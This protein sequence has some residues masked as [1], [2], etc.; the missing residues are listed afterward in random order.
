MEEITFSIF[1]HGRTASE[2][3]QVLLNQF[4]RQYGIHVRLEV[5]QF[6]SLRWPRLVEA[7]LY[8]SGPDISEVGNSWIGDLVRMDALRPFSED[9]VG[10]FMKGGK[11]FDSI[12]QSN[13]RISQGNSLIYSVPLSTDVRVIFYR[14]DILRSAGIDETLAFS[15]FVEM[16]RTLEV[17]KDAGTPMPLVLPNRRSNMTLHCCA[18]WVWAEGGNFLSPDGTQLTFDQPNALKGFKAF[19]HL[20]HHL[21]PEARNLEE[22]EADDVFGS[23][24]AAILLSG[25]WVPSKDMAD[26][27]R[28]NLGAASIPGIPFVGGGDLVIWNHSRHEMAA[29][30]LIKFLNSI[31]SSRDLYPWFGLPIREDDWLTPPFD[32]EIY[33]VFKIAIRKGRGFPPDRLW[34]LV[35]K[36]LTDTLADIWVEVLK[37]PAS[38]LDGVV[39]DRLLDLSSRLQL[40]LGSS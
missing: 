10:E 37:V 1:N 34:G 26:E 7:A 5:I 32:Q 19:F 13:V 22:H 38:K 6:S 18:S 36:R 15:N 23:G 25:Y 35:E 27:V 39:E 17:L 8:H 20:V 3:M 11:Y 29:L 24:K 14:R 12:W 31:D 9:E 40:S 28:K 21:V 30:T 16:E 2:N 33:Q 4:E